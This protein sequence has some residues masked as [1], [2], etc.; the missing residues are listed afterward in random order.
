VIDKSFPDGMFSSTKKPPS[1]EGGFPFQDLENCFHEL[2]VVLQIQ[3]QFN[4]FFP[5]FTVPACFGSLA[6]ISGGSGL[7]GSSV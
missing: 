6:S 2:G 1:P 5:F 7:L 4:P 3:P